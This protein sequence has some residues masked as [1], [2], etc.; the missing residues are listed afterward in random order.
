MFIRLRIH[1]QY[2]CLNSFRKNQRNKSKIF[3]RKCNSLKYGKLS[4]T[5][6]IL[7]LNK[8]NFEDEELPRELFFISHVTT[9]QATK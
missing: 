5:G 2:A 3:S 7:R 1:Q 9:R 4:R 6:T 8:K